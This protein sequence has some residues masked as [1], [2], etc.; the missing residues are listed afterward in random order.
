MTK[1]YK[2]VPGSESVRYDVINDT[3]TRF[4]PKEDGFVEKGSRITFNYH[5]RTITVDREW[6][7]LFTIFETKLPEQVWIHVEKIRFVDCYNKVLRL[8][9]NKIMVLD[10]CFHY[11]PYYRIVPG[12]THLFI[13]K[14]GVVIDWTDNFKPVSI[15]D[16]QY[17]N[18][19]IYDPERGFVRSVP[20]HRLLGLAWINNDNYQEKP[21]MNH[22]DGNKYNNQLSNLEW[23]SHQENNVH[24]SEVG[25]N[26]D[27]LACKARDVV[28]G[29]V[30]TFNSLGQ[31]SR[32]LGV[33][34]VNLE[35]L[36]TTRPTSLIGDR[37]EVRLLG[38]DTPWLFDTVDDLPKVKGR[39]QINVTHA[40]QGK[41]TFHD[42]R[43][44]VFNLK[45][46]KT[47]G[48]GNVR[49]LQQFLEKDPYVQDFE[50]I[51]H[52]KY[53]ATVQA[54]NVDTGEVVEEPTFTYLSR[55]LKLQRSAIKK[56][57][58]SGQVQCYHGWLIRLTSE[59]PWP[60]DYQ[61]HGQRRISVVA[62]HNKTGQCLKFPTLRATA[63]H[64][65][66]DRKTISVRINNKTD[67]DGWY[68]E[69]V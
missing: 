25:L 6:L 24:A 52:Y 58:N 54:K 68:F 60:E 34:A 49:T 15:L 43:T 20:L 63:R 64:F 45:Y 69:L 28:S 10:E 7:R 19:N 11:H 47:W 67:Y 1:Q 44:A 35:R 21:I 2:L 13:S 56:I 48:C 65:G 38:D 55:R 3:Y 27:S 51:D 50:I 62:K 33:G 26:T 9:T 5:N 17:K 31:L 42:V 37:Y 36:N 61:I 59:D 29:E 18:L 4:N 40:K 57:L 46:R 39:Y 32:A 16:D 66:I 14:N 41:L 22:I 12:F 53:T 30:Q 23:V 8:P